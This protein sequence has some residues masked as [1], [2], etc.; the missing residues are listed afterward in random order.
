MLTKNLYLILIVITGLLLTTSCSSSLKSFQSSPVSSRNVDLDPIKADILVNE[1]NKLSGS[2]SFAYFLIWKIK[3]ENNYSAGIEYNNSRFVG[4]AMR[5]R[6]AAAYDALSKGDYDLLISPNYN[7]KRKS[8]LGIYRT[9]EVTVTGYGG[10]YY[11]FR[12]EK[13]P[14]PGCCPEN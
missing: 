2:S 12:T 9:Y 4:E 10:K 14:I 3:G 1:E 6:S 13:E 5:A 8:Y 7:I 11:N